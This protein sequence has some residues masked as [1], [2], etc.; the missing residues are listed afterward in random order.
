MTI[1]ATDCQ[2]LQT[3]KRFL[4]LIDRIDQ[5]NLLMLTITNTL[6]DILTPKSKRGIFLS[7]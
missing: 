7:T 3:P 6:R 5:R 2:S 1:A 4:S